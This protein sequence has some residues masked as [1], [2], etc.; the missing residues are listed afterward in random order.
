MASH[1]SL[2]NKR[3]LVTG[4]AGFIGRQVVQALLAQGAIPIIFDKEPAPGLP[5][6]CCYYYGNL[7]DSRNT[8]KMHPLQDVLHDHF[9]STE[10]PYIIHLAADISVV[11]STQ[12]PDYVYDTNIAGSSHL[13]HLASQC[14]RPAIIV[15]ASSCA[16]YG[17][18]QTPVSER[19][20]I[21]PISPYG[22]SKR[23]METL[24][25]SYD[26]DKGPCLRF[27]RF[28]NVYGPGQ[29]PVYGAVINAFLLGAR[30]GGTLVIH[31]DGE[32]VRDFIAVQDIVRAILLTL[33]A[34]D[35]KNGACIN[36]G[37][38]EGV[39]ILQLATYIQSLSKKR[40]RITHEEPRPGDIK[41]SVANNNLA[42]V[43]L[44]FQPT[45]A[46]KDGIRELLW[47][48]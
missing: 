22:L 14:P 27:L 5:S 42:L 24:A 35:I 46:W 6:G 7:I 23:C 3:V 31:G 25:A 38:G 19:S 28:F 11:L 43:L 40:V 30:Q 37:T 21:A 39:S 9:S 48:K 45:K 32:Q 47:Q 33:M 10:T 18:S 13:F 36:I 34:P 29:N 26:Y 8:G 16:V 1:G 41:V 44:D 4:G 17:H 2:R 15:A 12:R 20:L